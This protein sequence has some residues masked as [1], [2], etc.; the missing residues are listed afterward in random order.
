MGL[1][2]RRAAAVVAPF[3]VFPF[4]LYPVFGRLGWLHAS[5]WRLTLL[6]GVLVTCGVVTARFLVRDVDGLAHGESGHP[7]WRGMYLLLLGTQV[8]TAL[9]YAV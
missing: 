6:A 9:V 2:A 5:T 8:G 3:L 4:V 7:A 1:G